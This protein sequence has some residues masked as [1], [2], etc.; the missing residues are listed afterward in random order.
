[1]RK[2]NYIGDSPC[3]KEKTKHPAASCRV[4]WKKQMKDIKSLG[5][6]KW[7]CKYY[8]NIDLQFS[9]INDRQNLI[10]MVISKA[11]GPDFKY[12]INIG[13]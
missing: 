1:M 5:H 11:F 7:K 12:S 6:R 10:D 13:E 4:S 9:V 2:T 8:L 3:V